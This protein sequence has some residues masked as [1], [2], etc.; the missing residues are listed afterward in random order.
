MFQDVVS[1]VSNVLDEMQ[2]ENWE[3][4]IEVGYLPSSMPGTFEDKYVM[5]ACLCKAKMLPDTAF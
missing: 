3:S 2:E 5:F 1:T 4:I